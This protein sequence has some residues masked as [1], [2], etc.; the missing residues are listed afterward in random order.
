MALHEIAEISEDNAAITDV[1]T[2]ID[3]QVYGTGF[4]CTKRVTRVTYAKSFFNL[5]N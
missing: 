3:Q 4:K 2:K 5:I 1:Y